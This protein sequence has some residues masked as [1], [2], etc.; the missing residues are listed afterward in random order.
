MFILFS[1]LMIL[2]N[3]IPFWTFYETRLIR[4]IKKGELL[5]GEI[6]NV[7]ESPT[8]RKRKTEKPKVSVFYKGEERILQGIAQKTD[9]RVGQKFNVY[10]NESVYPD[11]VLLDQKNSDA[12]LEIFEFVGFFLVNVFNLYDS[13]PDNQGYFSKRYGIFIIVVICIVSLVPSQKLAKNMFND[14]YFREE[15]SDEELMAVNKI[16]NLLENCTKL[17]K[18][19]HVGTYDDTVIQDAL[20]ALDLIKSDKAYLEVYLKVFIS[21]IDTYIF[22]D[23]YSLASELIES[24]QINKVLKSQSGS[25]NWLEVVLLLDRKMKILKEVGDNNRIEQLVLEGKPLM[26]RAEKFFYNT[27]PGTI[28]DVEIKRFYYECCLFEKDYEGAREQALSMCDLEYYKQANLILADLLLA[29]ISKIQGDMDEYNIRMDKAESI[30]R[31]DY[32]KSDNKMWFEEYKKKL[33]Y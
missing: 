9:F 12:F 21:L 16:K 15:I 6:I 17:Q 14:I 18:M 8:G 32:D 31:N 10:Y 1:F 27:N 23:K 5:S 33:G 25:Y 24:I 29:E 22:F 26:K 13:L 11:Y 20:K 19:R 4:T 3:L 2:T 30:A 7:N 28:M